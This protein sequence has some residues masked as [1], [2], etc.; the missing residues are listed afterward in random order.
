MHRGVARIFNAFRRCAAD[1]AGP[2]CRRGS[3]HR[4][5]GVGA[6]GDAERLLEVRLATEHE[7][8]RLAI[9]S[10]CGCGGVTLCACP[11]AP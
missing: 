5:Q 7:D 11:S 10:E 8:D 6:R 9:A 4:L 1:K 2:M 3:P